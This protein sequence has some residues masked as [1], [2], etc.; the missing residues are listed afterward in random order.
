MTTAPRLLWEPPAE[1]R[2]NCTMR[3]FMRWLEQRYGLHFTDYDSLYRWSVDE[4]EAFW[5]AL[6]EY[7]QIKAHAPYTTVLSS[8]EMPGARWFTGA[9]LNYAEHAFRHATPD[10]PAVIVASERQAPTPLSWETL[11]VQTA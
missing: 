7:Y 2:E 5:A 11:R 1:L 6:W 4:L 9:Q 8:R 3:A 10:R